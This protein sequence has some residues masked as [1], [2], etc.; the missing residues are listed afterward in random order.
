VATG[1]STNP[2]RR[3]RNVRLGVVLAVLLLGGGL[4][5]RAWQGRDATP[6]AS[7]ARTAAAQLGAVS[8]LGAQQAPPW[9]APPDAPARAK[10]AGLQLGAMGTAEHYHVHLDVLAN[11]RPVPVPA[12]IG[13]DG[14]SGAMSFL[15]THD[16][17]GVVHIEAGRAGQQFTLGQ[18]FTQWDVRLSATQ[19]GSLKAGAGHTLTAYVDGTQ[20]SGDPARLILAAHQ[21]IALVYGPAG[22]TPTVASS[23]PF[24]PGD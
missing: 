9:Q 23:Y 17:G 20:V 21:Q 4:V 8:G 13:V 6:T 2:Q 24:A 22:E 19:V 15:H 14:N 7:E 3:Q 18:L 5:L 16:P 1:P 11:G 12:N 10:A